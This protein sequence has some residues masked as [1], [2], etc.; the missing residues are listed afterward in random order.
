MARATSGSTGVIVHGERV[1]LVIREHPAG[2]VDDRDSSSDRVVEVI[3]DGLQA[4]VS[5]L[6]EQRLGHIRRQPGLI[7]QRP[8]RRI[9]IRVT[10][11]QRGIDTKR[12]RCRTKVE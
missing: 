10:Q 9:D 5:R 7:G 1:G 11:C 3:D 12:R 8:P 4:G 2:V 6:G